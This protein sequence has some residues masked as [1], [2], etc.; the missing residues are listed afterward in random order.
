M[1]AYERKARQAV[2]ENDFVAPAA[3][4]VA[5][6]AVL[7]FLTA[8]HVIEFVAADTVDRKLFTRQL[9]P[10][11]GAADQL[12]VFPVQR[13][14]GVAAV[15]EA[16][17]LPAVFVVAGLAFATVATVMGVVGAMAANAFGV[18]FLVLDRVAVAA[19]AAGTR[20]P[21]FEGEIGFTL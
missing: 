1:Q 18:R 4:L 5:T 3:G 9:A 14:I 6:S 11:T 21:A 13:E 8:V 7:A 2:V 16:G 15:V 17:F 12:V 19:F 20:V 10:M